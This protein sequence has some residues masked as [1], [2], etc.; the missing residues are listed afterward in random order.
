MPHP[1][2]EILVPAQLTR[3]PLSNAGIGF[4][5]RPAELAGLDDNLASLGM[6]ASDVVDPPSQGS[7]A[8]AWPLTETGG[9]DDESAV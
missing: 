7:N 1:G 3:D 8:P 9:V 4:G 6:P 2:M 5:K